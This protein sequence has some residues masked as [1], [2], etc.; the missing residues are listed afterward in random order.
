MSFL[1]VYIESVGVRV[2]EKFKENE[3]RTVGERF[4]SLIELVFEWIK[5]SF[6]FWIMMVRGFSLF[7]LIASFDSLVAVSLDVWYKKRKK[8]SE[9][10][11]HNY[12]NTD[13]KRFFSVLI[14][15]LFVYSLFAFLLPF[16]GLEGSL[17]AGLRTF[18]VMIIFCLTSLLSTRKSFLLLLKEQ[19]WNT[20]VH[21]YLMG[22]GLG[23][24]VLLLI[25]IGIVLWL[26]VMNLVFLLAFAPGIIGFV[27]AVTADRIVKKVGGNER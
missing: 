18:S 14:T 23:W 15:F 1:C 24:T 21:I 20:I 3:R 8:T 16:E 12:F 7:S 6:Y 27:G 13:R 10:F 9:N 19:K 5:H 22:R 11:K 2:V 17:R 25:V 4:Y 26:S